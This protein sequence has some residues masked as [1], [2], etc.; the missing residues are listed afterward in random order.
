MHM[1]STIGLPAKE[2]SGALKNYNLFE[3]SWYDNDGSESS[4]TRQPFFFFYLLKPQHA[5]IVP[6]IAA[7]AAAPSF[8]KNPIITFF[9]RP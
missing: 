4:L 9:S 7:A 6:I 2:L 8:N 1:E 3:L 5:E